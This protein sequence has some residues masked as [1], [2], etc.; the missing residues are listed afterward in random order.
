VVFRENQVEALGAHK[1]RNEYCVA[2]TGVVEARSD[3]TVNPNM[4]TGEIEV[5]VPI[6]A[7]YTDAMIWLCQVSESG[8]ITQL[9][10]RRSGGVAYAL[11]NATGNFASG[12]SL[13]GELAGGGV[14][15]WAQAL[16]AGGAVAVVL[17]AAALLLRWR[18]RRTGERDRTRIPFG[19]PAQGMVAAPGQM[20]PEIPPYNDQDPPPSG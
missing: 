17:L 7:E 8:V 13:A 18:H 9:E 5:G 1:L 6:P 15:V 4:A 19:T 14:P 12:Y 11:T 16:I 2:I 20:Y 3:D 10:T